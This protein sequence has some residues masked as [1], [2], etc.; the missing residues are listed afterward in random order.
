MNLPRFRLGLDLPMHVLS[1]GYQVGGFRLIG[2]A[3]VSGAVELIQ[4]RGDGLGLAALGHVDLP[5]GN[6]ES[7][8]GESATTG[9]GGLAV[10]YGLGDLLL[11]GDLGAASGTGQKLGPDLEWGGHLDY[12]AGAAYALTD[13]LGLAAELDGSWRWGNSVSGALPLEALGSV[14]YRAWRDLVLHAGAGAG[15]TQ[16]VGNPDFRVLAGLSWSPGLEPTALLTGTGDRDGDGI[17]DDQDLCVDQPEDLNG[18]DDLDGCP[19]AG[20]T[21]TR[22]RVLD[23]AGNNVADCVIELSAGPSTGSFTPGDGEMVRSL[24]PGK[25]ELKVTAKGYTEHRGKLVVPDQGLHEQLVRIEKIA[26]PGSVVITAKDEA[27]LPIA[28]RVRVVGEGRG[29]LGGDDGVTELSLPAGGYSLVISAN[30]YRNSEKAVT[31]EEG[32]TATVEVVLH[33]GRVKVEGDRVIITDKVF[34][35]LDSA[36]IKRESFSLLDEVVETLSNHPELK[37]VEIQGHT[38]DQGKDDYNLD[39]SMRRAQAV[40][41]YLVQGGIEGSRLLAQGYGE[42]QPLIAGTSDEARASNRRVEFH[43]RERGE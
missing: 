19:D 40:Q 39:L 35:E 25:Y 11:V 31:I 33:S 8:L 14:R 1:T 24:E 20:L 37:L 23:Q 17:P 29:E 2:D 28:A 18:V 32:G 22:I 12:G 16:G 4:R 42:S 6:E 30:G 38:D 36:V 15:L 34:F 26:A 43:I 10:S 27:G 13:S 3:R 41:T 7:W 9:G 5:S 21:P